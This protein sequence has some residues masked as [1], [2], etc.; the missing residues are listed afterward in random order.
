LFAKNPDWTQAAATMIAADEYRYLSPVFS[1]NPE[2]GV[3]LDIYSVALTNNPAIDNMAAV[4]MAAASAALNSPQES[5]MN[6]E[7]MERLRYLLNLPLTTT[8][9]EMLSQ[10]DKLKTIL[11]GTETT[12]AASLFDLLAKKDSQIAALSMQKPNPAEFVPVAV[13]TDL[14]TQVAALSAQINGDKVTGL[15]Q[16]ALQSGK[17][18]PA[19]EAWA[20]DLGKTNLAAL[21]AFLDTA[22]P[23][24]A[25]SGTQTGGHKPHGTD[26]PKL[27]GEELAVC[28]AMGL[29]PEQFLATKGA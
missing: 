29:T 9:A 18:L 15:V 13:M 27:T 24:A 12:A 17:L 3:V 19:Q 10:L 5:L 1:Y 2:T 21:T 16:N 22:Q 7:L 14:Q 11:G 4:S 26:K 8:V 6:E 23:I 28:S 20:T 25:L